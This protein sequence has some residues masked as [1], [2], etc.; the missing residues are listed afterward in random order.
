MRAIRRRGHGR[1]Y[2]P[3]DGGPLFPWSGPG[4]KTR[5]H[6]GE[7]QGRTGMA[8]HRR[9]GP[10][11]ESLRLRR[12]RHLVASLSAVGAISA[13][14]TR[15]AFAPSLAPKALEEPL[16]QIVAA[17]DPAQPAFEFRT[18]QDRVEETWATP[19]LMSFLLTTFA[20]LALTLAV[21]GFYGVLAFNGL[22]RLREIGVRLALGARAP[23]LYADSGSGLAVARRRIGDRA[24]RRARFVA[25]LGSLLFDVKAVDPGDYRSLAFSSRSPRFSPAGSPRGARH[26]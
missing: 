4:R 17:L 22:R 10:A 18:M 19:R 5:A 21:V 6:A 12:T 3:D 9:G 7:R 26:A 8:E 25:R 13:N 2:R 24:C 23:T 14:F 15:G 20:G 11:P 1:D 16:R